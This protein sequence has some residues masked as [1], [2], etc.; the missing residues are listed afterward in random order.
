MTIKD[1]LDTHKDLAGGKWRD[2]YEW[3]ASEGKYFTYN[4]ELTKEKIKG[5]EYKIKA[6]RCYNNS[7]DINYLTEGY[8]IGYYVTEI[9]LPLEHAFNHI[10][11]SGIDSTSA[12]MGFKV[13]ELF[14]VI[15]PEEVIRLFLC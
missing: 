15:V 1:Y 2:F 8:V 14:G 5:L 13:S 6:K 3:V 11:D 4:E 9:G 7:F 10:G 12:V